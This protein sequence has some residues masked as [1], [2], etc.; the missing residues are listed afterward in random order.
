MVLL[1][2]VIYIHL[3]MNKNWLNIKLLIMFYLIL[4][5]LDLNIIS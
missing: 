5:N 1:I 3:I 4:Y 2:I